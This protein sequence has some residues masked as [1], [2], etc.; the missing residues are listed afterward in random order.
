MAPRR[1][2]F[3]ADLLSRL[4]RRDPE[5]YAEV[6]RVGGADLLDYAAT[7]S[8]SLEAGQDV[9]QDVLYRVWSQGEDF[10]P[11]GTL[12]AYLFAAVRNASIDVLRRDRQVARYQARA[13]HEH[14]DTYE[15]DAAD[16]RLAAIEPLLATLSEHQ[17]TALRMRFGRGLSVAEVAQV[18][19]ISPE[20]AKKLLARTVAAIRARLAS[21]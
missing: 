14:H 2:E 6:F 12:A 15:H 18:L 4:Q 9:V 3:S 11:R 7:L 13:V 1:I 10:K 17:R 16:E 21:D 8:G 19:E 5:A 20:G